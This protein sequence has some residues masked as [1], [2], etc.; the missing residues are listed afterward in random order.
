ML[1]AMGDESAHRPCILVIASWHHEGEFRARIRRTEPGAAQPTS[2]MVVTSK[3]TAL[4]LVEEW[5]ESVEP[6]TDSHG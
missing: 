3:V 4:K 6:V 1:E 5:L 2:S